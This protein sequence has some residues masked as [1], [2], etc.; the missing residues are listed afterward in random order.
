MIGGTT[1]V[2]PDGTVYGETAYEQ[3]KFVDLLAKI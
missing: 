3:A 2:Q 1:A